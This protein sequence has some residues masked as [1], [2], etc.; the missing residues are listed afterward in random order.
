MWTK[1]EF[2]TFPFSDFEPDRIILCQNQNTCTPY[3]VSPENDD[4]DWTRLQ[5]QANRRAECKDNSHVP[6]TSFVGYTNVII[7]IYLFISKLLHCNTDAK[8]IMF[9]HTN[10]SFCTHARSPHTN[11]HTLPYKNSM[12]NQKRLTS[13][14]FFQIHRLCCGKLILCKHNY[15]SV[16]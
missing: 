14:I 3:N 11:R 2:C 1:H 12:E 8:K 16:V 13:I 4:I 15:F 5:R 9:L 7:N 6:L 10:S